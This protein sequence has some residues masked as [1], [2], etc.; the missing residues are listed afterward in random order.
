MVKR[1]LFLIALIIG[2]LGAVTYLRN[3]PQ[4]TGEAKLSSSADKIVTA[5]FVTSLVQT[6]NITS[7]EGLLGNLPKNYLS[8]FVLVHT[9][10]SIQEA[11][12]LNPRVLLV[13]IQD[14]ENFQPEQADVVIAFNGGLDK[15]GGD[16]LEMIQ[17]KNSE[18]LYEF[19]EIIFHDGQAKIS[20]KNP[21][22]CLRCHGR[23]TTQ[24]TPIWNPYFTW[25]GIY[26]AD[27]G[28]IKIGSLE[29]FSLRK[30]LENK[31]Q[32]PRYQYLEG[33]KDID[34]NQ[35][36]L[37]YFKKMKTY[38]SPDI[39]KTS[40]RYYI[41]PYI[42][43][44]LVKISQFFDVENFLRITHQI[45][46]SPN[47]GK[48]KN[49]LGCI[50]EM[51]AR[52]G[53]IFKNENSGFFM[54]ANDLLKNYITFLTKQAAIITG[55]DIEELRI[56]SRQVGYSTTSLAWIAQNFLD[57]DPTTWTYSPGTLSLNFGRPYTSFEENLNYLPP[58]RLREQTNCAEILKNAKA[59]KPSAQFNH[60]ITDRE[61]FLA[62]T[63]ENFPIPQV[64]MV[65]ATCHSDNSRESIPFQ[66]PKKL[67]AV[68]NPDLIAKI[69]Y[70]ISEQG[71]S[72]GLGMPYGEPI[73]S[74]ENQKKLLDYLAS[75][76]KAEFK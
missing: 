25:P 65:C 73:L 49:L 28:Q 41:E 30:F 9:S 51:Y 63:N 13:G 37:D 26:G 7:I 70:R 64:A 46:T 23:G 16:H 53:K 32:H 20:N 69:K 38:L 11:D 10:R 22:E 27:D 52:H 58:W 6:K 50:Q 67:A 36:K 39:F 29:D 15:F 2:C 18:K 1:K 40:G 56:S 12:H 57:L 24:G 59:E 43:G 21:Q 14:Y 34:F 45:E 71:Y 5:D 47:F 42:G 72:A 31:N 54:E 62:P 55:F 74:L 3:K 33:L 60:Y 8:S 76:Q 68:L 17:W 66:N 48:Y 4:T 35:S 61:D 19:S 44:G 75:I